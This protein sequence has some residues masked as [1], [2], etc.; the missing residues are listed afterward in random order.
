MELDAAIFDLGGVLTT[1]ILASFQAYERELGLPEHTF[2]RML[3][4]RSAEG[5]DP[6]FH[7]LE[8][9]RISE[10]EY[11]ARL[12]RHIEADLGAEIGWPDE[13]A[14][15]RAGLWGAIR[16]NDEMIDVVRDIARHYPVGLLTNN[17]K[18]WSDWRNAYPLEIFDVVVDSWE[19]GVRKP[20]PAIFRITCSKLGV[21]PHRASFVDDIPDFVESARQV[22]LVAR[23][24]TTTEEVVG[25]LRPLFPKAFASPGA[26]GLGGSD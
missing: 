6:D 10:E 24:F 1:P 21:E 18:E 15:I 13:P 7:L 20:D 16:R 25:W 3:P 12:R 23:V 4:M 14:S 11:Y 9:G 26:A 8:T 19:V 5:A 17:V 22:G 2:I